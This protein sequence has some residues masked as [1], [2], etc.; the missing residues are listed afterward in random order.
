VGAETGDLS[1]HT[2]ELAV[3]ITE[4]AL[5]LA[6]AGS[7]ARTARVSAALVDR[8]HPVAALAGVVSPRVLAPAGRFLPRPPPA[9]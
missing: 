5:G 2:S 1:R 3:Q 9:A 8:G 7:L 4:A 6:L